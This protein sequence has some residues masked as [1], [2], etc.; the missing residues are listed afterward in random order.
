VSTQPN[1][2]NTVD[3]NNYGGYGGYR[4]RR[5]ADDPYGASSSPQWGSSSGTSSAQ[6][7]NQGSD[8]HYVYGQQRQQGQQQYTSSSSS[9]Q[10]QQQAYVPPSSVTGKK[11]R[12][13]WSP[14]RFLS[15]LKPNQAA[16]FSYLLGF[17]GGLFFLF[18]ERNNRL[19]RFSAAQSVV[20]FLPLI[21]ITSILNFLIGVV[22][23]LFLIG[24]LAFPLS[25]INFLLVAVGVV[26]WVVL[27]L[28]A[29]QG[30]ELKLPVVGDYAERLL[31]L[32]TPRK[33]TN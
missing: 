10:Q 2:G 5:P 23:P 30:H 24:L 27:M 6:G 21:I 15:N 8:P 11:S 3:Q 4:P 13:S 7:G 12:P 32:F 18:Y 17:L 31:G 29:Y 26:L 20:L 19:V 33:R 16:F 22:S 25:A 9:N 28:R 14:G 1:Q